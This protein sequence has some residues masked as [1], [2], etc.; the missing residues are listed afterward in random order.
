M[1][2]YVCTLQ[3]PRFSRT[4]GDTREVDFERIKQVTYSWSEMNR[5]KLQTVPRQISLRARERRNTKKT[6]MSE[7]QTALYNPG[8]K[9]FERVNS[10]NFIQD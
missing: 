3:P 8:P 2:A 7:T 6:S 1:Y 10:T 9:S 4:A 5:T